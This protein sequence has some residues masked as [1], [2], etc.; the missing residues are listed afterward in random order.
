MVVLDTLTA[1]LKG[2][3]TRESDVF[4]AQYAEV[5]RLRK[6]AKEFQTVIIL[7]HHTRKGMCDSAVE[8][9]AG[10]GGIA[11]AVD[12]LWHLRRKP[13]GEAALDVV[14]REVEDKTLALRFDQ[15]PSGPQCTTLY[16]FKT[17]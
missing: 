10:T 9:V 1:M 14:G 6:V 4:R 2:G 8:A 7:V 11:A 3:G 12:T 17:R 16:L 15:Q 5:A 13:E